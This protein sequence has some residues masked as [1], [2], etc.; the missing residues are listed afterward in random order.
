MNKLTWT[1]LT[2]DTQPGFYWLKA[3][4]TK[5]E[6]VYVDSFKEIS[7]CGCDCGMNHSELEIIFLNYK[8]AK[9]EMP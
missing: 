4:F 9:M 5:P 1:K 2:D 8:I 3:E 6:P 7:R